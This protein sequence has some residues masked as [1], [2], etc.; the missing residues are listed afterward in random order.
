MCT[1]CG[2]PLLTPTSVCPLDHRPF[3]GIAW[4]RAP[5]EYAGTG[6]A[7]VRRLKLAGDFGAGL[8]L[9][10]AMAAVAAG[11]TQSPW[12]RAVLVGVPLHRSRRRRRGFDQAEFL[13]E[14]LGSRLGLQLCRGVLERL[15]PTLP[16]GD[17]RV[18]SRATN[19]AAAFAVARPRLVHGRRVILVDD[20]C[21][22]GATARACAAVLGDAGATAVALIT[23][24][25]A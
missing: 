19:V 12:R 7:L 13:A 1:R 20:V 11:P 5:Y 22:S 23:A 18:Q 25:R 24:C 9:A 4:V 10:R 3:A 14:Q 2:E 21:T 17:P 16:Q 6:G 8:L 15:R